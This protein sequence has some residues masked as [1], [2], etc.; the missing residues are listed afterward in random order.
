MQKLIYLLLVLFLIQPQGRAQVTIQDDD[1]KLISTE[2]LFISPYVEIKYNGDELFFLD[3]DTGLHKITLDERSSYSSLNSRGRGPGE[4]EY[5]D[6]FHVNTSDQTIIILDSNLDRVSFYDLGNFQFIKSY[7]LPKIDNASDGSPFSPDAIWAVQG[8]GEVQYILEYTQSFT[9][10]TVVEERRKKYMLYDSE[11]Q[12]LDSEFL[13]TKDDEDFI[14]QRYED[15][16]LSVSGKPFGREYLIDFTKK[17]EPI[18]MWTGE[19]CFTMAATKYCIELEEVK[20]DSEVKDL[21]KKNDYT[22]DEIVKLDKTFPFTS[23]IILQVN[24]QTGESTVWL[25]RY[26][27]IDHVQIL[28]YSISQEKIIN[29]YLVPKFLELKAIHDRTAVLITHELQAFVS[30]PSVYIVELK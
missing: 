19:P 22:K 13:L 3:W 29:T 20:I 5:V 26:T 25:S 18:T 21:L 4:F 30:D 23:T 16:G 10:S 6:N 28:E 14:F 2:E 15:G 12:I 8:N 11:F 24:K 27:G 1:L 9:Y 7:L 17:G